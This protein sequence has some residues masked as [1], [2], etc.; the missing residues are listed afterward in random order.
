MSTP[1][2]GEVMRPRPNPLTPFQCGFG[3][4][5]SACI[6]GP[7][8]DG[9]CC[10][11][12][13]QV[14]EGKDHCQSCVHSKA[15]LV[16]S[17]R[18]CNPEDNPNLRSCIPVKNYLNARHNLAFN[19]TVLSSGV[20]LIIMAL[21]IRE[22]IFVPGPLSRSHSQILENTIVSDRCSLC[23]PNAHQTSMKVTQD[24]LCMNCHK[25]H[26]PDAILS[27]PH[28][29]KQDQFAK[30][31][32]LRPNL[33][34]RPTEL[35]DLNHTQ[36][37]QCHVEHHGLE[38]DIKAITDARCQSCHSQQFKSF[39]QDHPEFFSFPKFQERRLAFDHAAHLEKHFAQKN[40]NFDCKSCHELDAENPNEIRRTGS[41]ENTCASCH[42]EPLRAA[43]VD[44]WAMLQLP[45]L[46]KTDLRNGG[47]LLVNWPSGALYGYDGKISLPMRL[48]L[49]AEPEV[50]KAIGLFRDGDLSKVSPRD[51]QQQ[52][53]A[54]SIARGLRQL[55]RDTATLGQEAWKQRLAAVATMSLGR[56]PN[57][58]EQQLIGRM[59][60]G[61]PPDLFRQ[62]ELTWFGQANQI[63]SIDSQRPNLSLVSS[64]DDLLGDE[65]KD[66][67][68]EDADSLLR[69][70]ST[71][72]LKSQEAK[73][74]EPSKTKPTSSDNELNLDDLDN[75]SADQLLGLPQTKASASDLRTNKAVGKLTAT[76][77]VGEGGWYLDSQLYSLKYMP[78]GHADT[79]LA[80][81][82][83]FAA[84]VDRPVVQANPTTGTEA[85]KLAPWHLPQW[86]PGIEAVGGCTECH[87]LPSYAQRIQ[88][89]S[90]DWRSLPPSNAKGFTKFNHKPH[91]TLA[92]TSDC[93]HCHS[94]DESQSSRLADV[95]KSLGDLLTR[96]VRHQSAQQHFDC[97]F[98][99]IEKSQCNACHRPGGA[100]QGCTQCHN[101]HV[102]TDGLEATLQILLR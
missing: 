51:E 20:L 64:Q 72:F 19:L 57:S 56:E 7:T 44:G 8:A 42:Q 88:I 17:H 55:F 34:A 40:A 75:L 27:M 48:L 54:A 10:Q 67:Q 70:S 80:A 73:P 100:N 26:M 12:T 58:A 74:L 2:D 66:T 62:A 76:K 53:A 91:M 25:A 60:T 39:S 78:K 47:E 18:Q 79:V 16:A 30:L 50:A 6:S 46:N 38:N 85:G 83:Q 71:Q 43:V 96:Y 21:P 11:S 5:G 14:C 81:W 13:K 59:V 93:K 52:Q 77:L 32:G 35:T 95:Q 99:A 15:C 1:N 68:T 61:L 33:S 28:D 41:F 4:I 98:K 69:G 97:E 86:K 23:H 82:I 29:L 101:Y 84:L 49:S 63:S 37:A 22:S 90:D 24:Q 94:L 36:C 87:L 45:S 89:G 3:E 102:G 9:D 65:S 31:V 92:A